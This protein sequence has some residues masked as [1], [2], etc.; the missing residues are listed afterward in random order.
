ML[1]SSK[2]NKNTVAGT[3]ANV[4]QIKERTNIVDLIGATVYLKRSGKEY[5]GCCPFHDDKSPSFVVYPQDEGGGRYFCFGCKATGDSIDWLRETKGLSFADAI[6][7][8]ASIGNIPVELIEAIITPEQRYRLTQENEAKRQL[9]EVLALIAALYQHQLYKHSNRSL[10]YLTDERKLTQETI[11]SFGLGYA[12]GGDFVYKYLA[13]DRKLSLD[14]LYKAG[15]INRQSEDFFTNRLIIPIRDSVGNVIALGARSLNEATKPKYLNS[16]DNPIF[17]KSSTL[18][19]LDK[20]VEGIKARDQAIIVEGYFDVMR[21][22]QVG[23]KNA[24]A[25]MGT[26]LTTEQVLLLSRYTNNLILN[27][28]SDPAGEAATER[29]ENTELLDF[30]SNAQASIKV[31]TFPAPIKDAD[32]YLSYHSADQYSQLIESSPSFFQW[33][34]DKKLQKENLDAVDPSDKTGFYS[35]VE[36]VANLLSGLTDSALKGYHLNYASQ[37]LARGN[38]NLAGIYAQAIVD[39]MAEPKR[40]SKPRNKRGW[41]MQ[42][43]ERRKEIQKAYTPTKLELIEEKL[44]QAWLHYPSHRQLIIDELDSRSLLIGATPCHKELWQE[45]LKAYFNEDADPF[46]LDILDKILYLKYTSKN[47][48]DFE[49]VKLRRLLVNDGSL[50]SPVAVISTLARLEYEYL[51]IHWKYCQERSSE[52]YYWE[53]LK[54]LSARKDQIK[55]DLFGASF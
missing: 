51:D 36:M 25:C 41:I 23:I 33:L 17:K 8:L 9:H 46:E 1:K 49:S 16:P 30:S 19:G 40:P 29:L 4:K 28:D 32:D 27:A 18:F 26:S 11:Q 55:R 2:L 42:A 45:M 50:A 24:V 21:L 39:K 48:Y 7:E 43:T 6:N 3:I 14:L 10:A 47:Q 13:K 12:P 15:L 5:K 37:I 54:I 31:C 52:P 38:V 22:H 34:L 35:R 53:S 20:A 44:F